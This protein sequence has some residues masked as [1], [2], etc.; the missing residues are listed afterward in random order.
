MPVNIRKTRPRLARADGFGEEPHASWPGG[1]LVGTFHSQG[2]S[3][4]NGRRFNSIP[5]APGGRT[6]DINFPRFIFDVVIR[7]AS[8]LKMNGEAYCDRVLAATKPSRTVSLE[9]R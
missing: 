3:G 6:R 7:L 2:C 5:K 1:R 8:R 4:S 9:V